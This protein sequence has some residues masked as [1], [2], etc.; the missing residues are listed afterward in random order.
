MPSVTAGNALEPL[1]SSALF[2]TAPTPA[3]GLRCETGSVLM[4][5]PP[6]ADGKQTERWVCLQHD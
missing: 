1:T 6:G 4:S 3:N 2:S 5:A